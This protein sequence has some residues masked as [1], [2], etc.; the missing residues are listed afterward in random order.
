MMPARLKNSL[1]SAWARTRRPAIGLAAC[2]LTAGLVSAC[3]TPGAIAPSTIPVPS[4]YV[5]LGAAEESSSCGFMILVVPLKNPKPVAD[6]IDD[7]IK[8]RGGDALI[9]VSSKSSFSTFL[10]FTTSCVEIRGKVVKFAR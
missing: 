4:K 5:E 7:M 1:H 6:V 3:S 9:E 10:L 2:A 8:S